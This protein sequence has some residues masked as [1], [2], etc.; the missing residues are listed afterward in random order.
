MKWADTPRIAGV[1]V[2]VH[3]L[4]PAGRPT[5]VTSDLRSFW[6]NGYLR[7]R[8]ELKGRYPKHHWPERPYQKGT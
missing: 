4:S 1:P 3:L 6:R 2:V 7:V 8:S 5:A